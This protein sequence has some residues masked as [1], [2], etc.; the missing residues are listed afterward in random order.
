[1]CSGA[2]VATSA[3]GCARVADA[4]ASGRGPHTGEST[5]AEASAARLALHRRPCRSADPVEQIGAVAQTTIPAVRTVLLEPLTGQRAVGQFGIP[6]PK[7]A[8]ASRH[9]ALAP[10]TVA[11]DSR[12]AHLP[13]HPGEPQ[14][15][16][17]RRALPGIVAG[18]SPGTSAGRR[19]RSGDAP[20][21]SI[22][23]IASLTR[24]APRVR[25][26]AAGVALGEE[27]VRS[28][29]TGVGLNHWTGVA[30][31]RSSIPGTEPPFITTAPEDHR[32]HDD[33]FRRPTSCTHKWPPTSNIAPPC[34]GRTIQPILLGWSADRCGR[35]STHQSTP[36]TTAAE[37]TPSA[38]FV[39]VVN[40][41]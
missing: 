23:H 21:E 2:A 38:T 11:I 41:P 19:A 33:H 27:T 16:E 26:R 22:G 8:N 13:T 12:T 30:H 20:V 29:C 1:M 31:R 14:A 15:P 18:S 3:A 9:R 28:R 37:P 39:S 25:W 24:R 32:E 40:R 36:L 10:P 6:H 17:S 7:T 5:A 35:A 4:T 34:P